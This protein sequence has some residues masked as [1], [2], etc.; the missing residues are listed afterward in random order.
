MG[1]GK[2]ERCVRKARRESIRTAGLRG[3]VVEVHRVKTHAIPARD[4]GASGLVHARA[5]HRA[6]HAALELDRLDVCAEQASGGALEDAFEDPFD[7]G[8]R[9]HGAANRT[10]GARSTRFPGRTATAL[11]PRS[12][13]PLEPEAILWPCPAGGPAGRFDLAVPRGRQHLTEILTESFC[14]RCGTRYTF[15]SAAPRKSR[16]G[17]VRVLGKGMRNFVLSDDASLSEAMADARSE[18]EIAATAHQLDAFHQTFNFCLTCRQYTCGDCWNTGEGR[19]LTCAPI[20]G[21]ELPVAEVVPLVAI[22]TEPVAAEA[23]NGHAAEEAW[24]DADLSSARLARAL[25]MDEAEA[26]AAAVADAEGLADDGAPATAAASGDGGPGATDDSRTGQLIGI[27][28]GQSLEEAIAEYEARVAADEAAELAVAARGEA[29][30]VRRQ[31]RSQAVVGRGDHDA[32]AAMAAAAIAGLARD[33]VSEAEPEP[34]PVVAIEAEAE[35]VV[36]VEAEA[37]PVVAIEAEAEPVVAVEAEAEPVVA[38]S[39][40]RAGRRSRRRRAGDRCRARRRGRGRRGVRT[41]GEDGAVE[42]ETIAAAPSP[43]PAVE[44]EPEPVAAR[45][46]PSRTPRRATT[47]SRSPSGRHPPRPRCRPLPPRPA[48]RPRLPTRGSPWRP[49][50]PA[51]RR[52]GRPRRPGPRQRTVATCPP[53]SP[54]ARCSRRPIRRDCGPPPRARS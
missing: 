52:N 20:P 50:T 12:G 42:P 22:A 53:R 34:Q 45:P 24:P 9:G 37:E 25:G 54:A 32:L 38:A 29:V 6:L 2:R 27:P 21:M 19:C 41:G 30:D 13:V 7:V 4:E 31:C 49:T 8:E 26:G 16:L 5:L 39:R 28:P 47:S 36:A 14:E 11:V 23:T 43:E 46:V 17:R 15:E 1:P 18:E 33:D 3:H 40:A 35:P 10:R 51:R 48:S 44:P